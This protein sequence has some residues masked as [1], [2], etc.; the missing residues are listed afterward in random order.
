LRFA[1]LRFVGPPDNSCTAMGTL[2][3]WDHLYAISVFIVYPIVA[4]QTFPALIR[5]VRQGGEEGKV[6]A[7]RHTLLS[8]AGLAIILG[9][10]W[11]MLGRPWSDLGIRLSSPYQ[12]AA[13]LVV[14]VVVILTT[15]AQFRTAQQ[16]NM[17]APGDPPRDLIALLPRSDREQR[18]FRAVAA[19]AGVSEELIFR[20]YLIWYFSQLVSLLTAAF[21]A[22]A[23]FTFAHSYQGIRQ[24]PGLL[25]MSTVLVGLYFLS[26]S[27]LLPIVLHATFDMVQGHYI[28]RLP[29][30]HA[31]PAN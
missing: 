16:K 4:K 22:I 13:G 26:G 9:T 15:L 1:R 5:K 19:N 23:L 28:A 8:L 27:L 11:L 24:V 14:C 20:G 29:Q 12:L 21:I 18:W 17:V 3:L 25:I 2:T 7:Y 10:M 30:Q 31:D 6:T